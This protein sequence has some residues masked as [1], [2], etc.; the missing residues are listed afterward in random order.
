V[1]A[2]LEVAEVCKLLLGQG[3]TLRGRQLLVDLQSME[4]TVI[5]LN[6]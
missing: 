4:F 1:V 3:T 6:R 2:S 5:N